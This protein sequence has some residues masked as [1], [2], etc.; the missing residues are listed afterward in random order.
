MPTAVESS[1]SWLRLVDFRNRWAS[2]SY[3][4][5]ASSVVDPHGAGVTQKI[6]QGYLVVS[7]CFLC[8][9]ES[10]SG[11]AEVNHDQLEAFSLHLEKKKHV[12]ASET[13]RVKRLNRQDKTL[14]WQCQASQIDENLMR[15]TRDIS[16]HKTECNI[17]FGGQL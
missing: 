6:S 8:F 1:W 15:N 7:L 17:N 2:G 10:S 4:G 12:L 11:L 9:V 13:T 3:T 5:F 16:T 14:R